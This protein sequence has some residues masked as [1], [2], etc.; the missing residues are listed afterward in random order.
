[1]YSINC[2]LK[3]KNIQKYIKWMKIHQNVVYLICRSQSSFY[4][5][6]IITSIVRFLSQKKF[7]FL[8]VVAFK[9]NYHFNKRL[10][11]LTFMH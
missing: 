9:W 11:N 5:F 8:N 1:M 4:A 3:M 10:L 2:Q 7:F 6:I